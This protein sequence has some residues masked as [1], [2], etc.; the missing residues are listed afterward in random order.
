[1]TSEYHNQSMTSAS[2]TPKKWQHHASM[3]HNPFFIVLGT[4]FSLSMAYH[5]FLIDLK[6]FLLLASDALGH[7]TIVSMIMKIFWPLSMHSL[8]NDRYRIPILA[9]CLVPVVRP[10]LQKTHFQWRIYFDS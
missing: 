5:S 4:F 10:M 9:I 2:T 7:H 1:M 6:I 8:V 3:Q